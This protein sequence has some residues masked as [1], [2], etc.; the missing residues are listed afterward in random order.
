MLAHL[1]D[2]SRCQFRMPKLKTFWSRQVNLV[3]QEPPMGDGWS[4]R[5]CFIDTVVSPA[6]VGLC[7]SFDHDLW[8]SMPVLHKAIDTWNCAQIS[9]PA[10]TPQV[11]DVVML[12]TYS[13]S[14]IR[15]CRFAAIAANRLS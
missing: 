6:F 11:R 12:L 7:A 3:W 10:N 15:H 5:F 1:L 4:D 14:S 8:K 13:P 2:G 9:A